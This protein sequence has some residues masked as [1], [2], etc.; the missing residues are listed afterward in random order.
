MKWLFGRRLRTVEERL[1]ERG[2]MTVFYLRLIFFMS[3]ALN[4]LLSTTNISYRNLLLGTLLGAAHNIILNAWLS[5]M[6]I[7]LIT[8]GKS[9]NPIE[10]PKL[11]LPLG[12][13]IV[14]FFTIRI[15]DGRRRIRGV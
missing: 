12:I 13:G 9:L 11:L 15:I 4:W 10:T 3:P 6:V 2:L 1:D 5:G 7:E 8:A 14:I